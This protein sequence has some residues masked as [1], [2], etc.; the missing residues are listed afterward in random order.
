MNYD[1]RPL[2]DEQSCER[3][4]QL[5]SATQWLVFGETLSLWAS[6]DVVAEV[7]RDPPG[8]TDPAVPFADGEVMAWPDFAAATHPDVPKGWEARS[9]W[10]RNDQLG[11]GSRVGDWQLEDGSIVNGSIPS[12]QSQWVRA[13]RR[14]S[15]KREP[16]YYRARY[17]GHWAPIAV[18]PSGRALAHGMDIDVSECIDMWG[19]QLTDMD[20]TPETLP[21][22]VSPSEVAALDE[23]HAKVKRSPAAEAAIKQGGARVADEAEASLCRAMGVDV[24]MPLD[25]LCFEAAKLR[26]AKV[27]LKALKVK[28]EE[29]PGSWSA[30]D[31]ALGEQSRGEI[32]EKLA[33]AKRA[34]A[35]WK[36]KAL[37][38]KSKQ[39]PWAALDEVEGLEVF[40]SR[41]GSLVVT[42]DDA[43]MGIITGCLSRASDQYV[44]RAYR[45]EL[46]SDYAQG[47]HVHLHAAIMALLKAA[48]VL[49]E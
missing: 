24:G 15:P 1:P 46:G 44:F 37:A 30:L 28:Q 26:M 43:S 3:F 4:A 40:M 8:I 31:G 25:A 39:G 41:P 45:P 13:L 36:E 14:V 11:F 48:G 22:E 33:H 27:E 17:N 16:G 35:M 21:A 32:K 42:V 2:P 19:D 9:E 18:T 12:P 49:N 29:P 6:V 20:L 47:N 5:P 23:L 7:Q 10:V 34:V 38:L